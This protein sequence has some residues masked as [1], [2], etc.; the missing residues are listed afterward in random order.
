[1]SRIQNW[2]RHPGRPQVVLESDC[3]KVVD[4]FVSTCLIAAKRVAKCHSTLTV[5]YVMVESWEMGE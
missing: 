3:V 4:K 1:M 2:S 5:G